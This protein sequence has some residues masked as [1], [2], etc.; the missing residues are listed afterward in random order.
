VPLLVSALGF[1][2]HI[3]TATSHFVLTIMAGTSTVTHVFLGSFSRGHGFHRAA[4]LSIGVVVGA[5][6][7]ACLAP[8]HG[9][10]IQWLVAT[11]LFAP[12]RPLIWRLKTSRLAGD[13]F[14]PSR[15]P[16]AAARGQ[17]PIDW[18][19]TDKGAPE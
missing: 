9:I 2:T 3:A 13:P 1:P 11:A 8:L 16:I 18:P 17:A 7:G 12:R 5:Q 10:A 14:A 15:I 6:V 19:L 4:A